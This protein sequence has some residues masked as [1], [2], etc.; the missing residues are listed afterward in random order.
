[1]T[2]AMQNTEPAANLTYHDYLGLDQVLGA[3]APRSQDPNEQLFIIQHQTSELWMKLMIHELDG[4]M[5]AMRQHDM[6]VAFKMLARVSRVFETL[7]QGW[8]VLNTMT[9]SEY[10]MMRPSLGQSSGL[11][12]WQYRAIEMILGNKNA[13]HLARYRDQPAIDHVLRKRLQ[14]RS[15]YDE[16]LQVVHSSGLALPAEVLARD[17]TAPY[18]AHVA[19]EQAWF[20][21]Y[22]QPKAHWDLY[23][24]AEKLVDIEEAF[25]RWRFHH[26]TTVERIIGFKQGTGG[27][28]GVSYLKRML[29][30]VLFPE[31][32][33]VRTRL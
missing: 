7:I 12:S 5:A 2:D 16:A 17:W 11:Q 15:I 8:S 23:Q 31:L 26:V 13:A 9:P 25:R 28:A 20:A 32:W 27:T 18:V 4:A 22:S 33:T 21:V 29:D 24:L 1:M 14:A 30:V 19:V 6:P 3:Q 10:S